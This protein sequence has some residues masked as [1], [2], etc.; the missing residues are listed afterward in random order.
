[1]HVQPNALERK[2]IQYI[3]LYCLT[4]P[5]FHRYSSSNLCSAHPA[6]ERIGVRK[7]RFSAG[8]IV[9]VNRLG[10]QHNEQLATDN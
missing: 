9:L 1:M 6:G 10:K 7:Y 8:G 3:V 5:R 4:P 2:A